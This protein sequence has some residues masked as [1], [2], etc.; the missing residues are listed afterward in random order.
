[1]ARP[2]AAGLARCVTISTLNPFNTRPEWILDMED[3]TVRLVNRFE[4]K[5]R[6][7]REQ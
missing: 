6:K 4:K 2:V 3:L 7:L 1:M 5:K